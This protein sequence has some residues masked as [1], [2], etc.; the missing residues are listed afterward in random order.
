MAGD[1]G[2]GGREDER[3]VTAEDL[4]GAGS[5]RPAPPV[6]DLGAPSGEVVLPHWT[7]PATGQVPQ[8][9][10]GVDAADA[11]G[12]SGG[13]ALHWRDEHDTSDNT[14]FMRDLVAMDADAQVTERLGAL[15]TSERAL[16]TEYLNFDDVELDPRRRGRGRTRRTRT[17]RIIEAEG[18]AAPAPPVE[19][20]VGAASPPP[21]RPASASSAD[22]DGDTRT[23]PGG[24]NVPMAAAV[25]AAM[26]A[27]ALFAFSLGPIGALLVVELVVVAAGIEFFSALQRNGFRPAT[28]LG[29]AAVVVF[30]LA[31]YWKGEAAVPLVLALMFLFGIIWYV[32]GLGGRSRPVANLGVTFLSVIWIGMFGAFAALILKVPAEGVSIL[33]L[34]VVGT[35]GS[36]VGAFFIGRAAGRTPLSPLSPNKTVEGLV[37]GIVGSVVLVFLCSVILGVGPFSAGGALLLGFVIA[38][39]APIGDLAESLFKRDL[40]IKDMGTLLPQHGG[41]LDRFDGM[42]LVLPAAYYVARLCGFVS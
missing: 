20:G 9:V 31:T 22:P 37:G 42:L 39:V 29:V 41:V 12:D 2:I 32:A 16:D 27:V 30:P 21:A 5:E 3:F 19:P 6:I 28:L 1:D 33:V 8:V 10:L 34:A 26:A 40:G 7:A 17:S 18:G 11:A 15:D 13:D 24:R 23:R 25:G 36:D 4:A 35:V 38:I 14:D